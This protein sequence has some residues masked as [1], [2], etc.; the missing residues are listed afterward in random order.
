MI[1]FIPVSDYASLFL[2]TFVSGIILGFLLL[3]FRTTKDNRD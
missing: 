2:E 1:E 3:F